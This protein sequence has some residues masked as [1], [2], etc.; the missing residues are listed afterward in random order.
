KNKI[1]DDDYYNYYDGDHA[2]CAHFVSK[3]LKAGG[4]SMSQKKAC[5]VKDN[6]E[7]K[8]KDIYYVGYLS[9]IE[10]MNYLVEKRIVRLMSYQ[11]TPNG[12]PDNNIKIPSEFRPGDI[13]WYRYKTEENEINNTNSHIAIYIGNKYVAEH[14]YGLYPNGGS[15][16]IKPYE[17]TCGNYNEGLGGQ[18]LVG[19]DLG[20]IAKKICRVEFWKML[21][22]DVPPPSIPV[23]KSPSNGAQNVSLTPR[24]EW[25]PVNNATS[26]R[27]QVINSS[28]KNL[29][30]NE[31]NITNTYFEI[32][33][34]KL[35]PN[36]TYD[37]QVKAVNQS[38]SDFCSKW[39]FKT[40]SSPNFSISSSPI[41]RTISPGQSTTYSITVTSINGFN[42]SVS[43][44]LSGLPSGATYSFSKQSGIPTFSSTLTINTT[45]STPTGTY[46]LTITGSGGGLIR[47]TQVTLVI[48]NIIGEPKSIHTWLDGLYD[49][50]IYNY[51]IDIK[52][53][54]W[55]T[56]PDPNWLY[57]WGI[58]VSFSDENG[59]P[60]GG[61]HGGLQWAAGG[62]KANWGGYELVGGTQSIVINYNWQPN[63]WYR[64]RVWG[65][66]QNSDG[67]YNWGFW[68]LDY[69]T[70][71]ETYI[72]SVSS[73]GKYISDIYIF[74][75]T[76]Y[77]VQC[78]TPTV[79]A[80]W[81]NPVYK[82][83]T[84]GGSN[85][86]PYHG[87]ATYNGTC[88]DPNNTDQRLIS[89]NPI[90]FI[91]LT[92]TNRTIPNNGT[93]FD[94]SSCTPPSPPS[95]SSP[96]N[97]AMNVS[98][99]PTFSWNPSSGTTP[100][101]Y[102]LQISTNSSFSSYVYNQNIGTSTSY[103]L[104]SGKLN[105][106]TTYYWRVKATNSCGEQISS[107][108]SFKTTNSITPPTTYGIMSVTPTSW[109]PSVN[110]GSSTSKEFTI[111][112]SN[113]NILG[114]T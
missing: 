18:R 1:C 78:N 43:L 68:I 52:I 69:E 80:R 47:T 17:Q 48:N 9:C 73:W 57:F 72:G 29:I 70:N 61:A 82:S 21:D 56:N 7:G 92:N 86:I 103:T 107:T 11:E 60:K 28:S 77:G 2:D 110:S 20:N 101:N 99:T 40:T 83:F 12:L 100:I 63:K 26:Y 3:C 8:Y 90:E 94:I 50:K 16:E 112:A 25:Y 5:T 89:T 31:P 98:L 30:I 111:L 81:R 55:L 104:P 64:Y 23:L 54:K 65:L 35:Q 27:L 96:S 19:G 85:I 14:S 46:N 76:G 10:L 42:S 71:I 4:I 84:I 88:S 6:K 66:G 58:C 75:E 51:D 15:F 53:D 95:L 97:G 39:S 105:P 62:K 24:L 38:E 36:T 22:Q 87:T 106:S 114:V 102:T 74:T 44:S 34:G 32:P 49:D 41:S 59:N 113:G 45:S 33:M 108:W 109:S 13:V 79:Q 91:H 67:S 37:W 93:L